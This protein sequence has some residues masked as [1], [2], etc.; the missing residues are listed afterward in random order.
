[1]ISTLGLTQQ[2][3]GSALGAALGGGYVNYF[4]I[5]GARTRSSRR[6]CRPIA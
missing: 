2:D 4:S 5:A 1:M 6:C 3:V